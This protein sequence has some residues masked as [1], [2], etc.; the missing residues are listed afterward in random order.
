M[1]DVHYKLMESPILKKD[2]I[3]LPRCEFCHIKPDGTINLVLIILHK[4]E[5]GFRKG[6]YESLIRDCRM[7]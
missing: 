2:G 7:F 6:I 3:T 5:V 1:L 4:S